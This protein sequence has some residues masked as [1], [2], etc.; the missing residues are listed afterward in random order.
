MG[1]GVGDCVVSQEVVLR[2]AGHGNRAGVELTAGLCLLNAA[3]APP[4]QSPPATASPRPAPFFLEPRERV[5][6]D[7]AVLGLG[8]RPGSV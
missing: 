6:S 4:G 8:V 2:L 3:P 5:A 1:P 7:G